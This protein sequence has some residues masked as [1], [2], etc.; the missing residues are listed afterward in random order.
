MYS[1]GDFQPKYSSVYNKYLTTLGVFRDL[2][3]SSGN[4]HPR[5][6][7]WRSR[8][9]ELEDCLDLLEGGITPE[10]YMSVNDWKPRV[11]PLDTND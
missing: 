6:D 4:K 1:S 5:L 7:Y 11:Q 10:G 3:L 2:V 9:E 8:V